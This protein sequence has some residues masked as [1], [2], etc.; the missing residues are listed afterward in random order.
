[1]NSELH[2]QELSVE[3]VDYGPPGA[4][5]VAAETVTV[6]GPFFGYNVQPHS[7]AESTSGKRVVTEKLQI[8]GPLLLQAG[9]GDRIIWQGNKYRIEAKP[10]HYQS[11][12]L[13]HTEMIVVESK[14]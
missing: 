5:G 7:V 9:E 4:D 14:G 8:S 2:Q 11:G 10:R 13:D 6:L 1:M 12:I 3:Q